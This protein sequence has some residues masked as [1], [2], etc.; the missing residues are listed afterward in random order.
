VR[1]NIRNTAGFCLVI[2][3]MKLVMTNVH[4][5]TPDSG[6]GLK[7][8]KADLGTPPEDVTTGNPFKKFQCC[9]P[10]NSVDLPVLL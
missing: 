9:L 4:G 10:R 1:G 6:V 5:P 3:F 8:M 2:E 7:R